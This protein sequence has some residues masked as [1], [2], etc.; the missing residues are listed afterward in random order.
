MTITTRLFADEF[1]VEDTIVNEGFEA[2]DISAPIHGKTEECINVRYEDPE[3]TVGIKNDRLGCYLTYKRDTLPDFL[4]WK[5]LGESE[6]VVGLEPRTTSFGGQNIINNNKYVK[7]E[8][9]EEYK[10]YL[11]FELKQY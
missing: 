7:L 3:V 10:T 2:A 1:T 5:M 11:K 8:A 6:Y 4:I 9:F